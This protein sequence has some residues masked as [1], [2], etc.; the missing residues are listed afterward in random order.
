MLISEAPWYMQKINAADSVYIQPKLNGWRCVMN[1]RTGTLY[2]RNGNIINLLHIKA[3]ANSPEWIDGELYYHGVDL[4]TIQSMIK[5]QDTRIRLHVFDA[6]TTGVFSER[7]EKI[8]GL[9][10]AVQTHKIKPSEI[11]RYY[12]DFLKAGYEG[13]IIRLNTPYE[14]KRSE[15]IF[16]M[17]PI[18]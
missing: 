3:P 4:G 7:W 14:N 16:K 18:Y 17:K 9:N 1:T 2:S 8:K 13:A 11:D 10:N 6:I 15:N 5:K 12:R